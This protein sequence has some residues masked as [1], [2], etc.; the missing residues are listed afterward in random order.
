MAF[1]PA[2]WGGAALSGAAGA[3][4]DFAGTAATAYG[5]SQLLKPK[6][7]PAPPGPPNPNDAAQAAQQTT[8]QLRARRGL[9]SNIYAGS[10]AG[11]ASVGK[12]Q[13][14]T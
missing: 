12:T 11:Q 3:A 14:G 9:L 13:L 4:A 8:D 1:L 2:L 7:P 5:A 6:A 10:Q